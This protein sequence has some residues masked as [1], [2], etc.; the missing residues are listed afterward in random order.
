MVRNPLKQIEFTLFGDEFQK[1]IQVFHIAVGSKGQSGD[2]CLWLDFFDDACRADVQR[3][4]GFRRDFLSGMIGFVPNFPFLHPILVAGHQRFH[5]SVPCGV[6]FGASHHA[7]QQ[8]DAAAAGV[9]WIA[10][11]RL[12]P[13]FDVIGYG[14][15]NDFIQPFPIVYAG[16]FFTFGPTCLEA[17]FFYPKWRQIGF[18]IVPYRMTT[19]EGLAAN[20]DSG[21]FNFPGT[22]RFECPQ[23]FIR[24]R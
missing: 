10:I 9:G 20:G 7:V 19:V 16:H 4:G 13:G 22:T 12:Q 21:G 5:P 15:I 11:G 24:D 14:I 1:S 17:D 6:T 18:V 8:V 2:F 23:F 3:S